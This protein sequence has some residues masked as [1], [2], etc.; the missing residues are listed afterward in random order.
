METVRSKTKNQIVCYSKSVVVLNCYCCYNRSTLFTALIYLASH[1][2]HC[3][4]A[5]DPGTHY[6][7]IYICVRVCVTISSSKNQRWRLSLSCQIPE[8]SHKSVRID[9]TTCKLPISTDALY[10]YHGFSLCGLSMDYVC[11]ILSA[12]LS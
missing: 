10:L 12:C 5:E 3:I 11:L 1:I 2:V 8:S 6:V 9:D 7:D 4:I